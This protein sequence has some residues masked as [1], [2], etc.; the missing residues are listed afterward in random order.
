MFLSQLQ[1]QQSPIKIDGL[2]RKY[3]GGTSVETIAV[4]LQQSTNS[5]DATTK[6]CHAAPQG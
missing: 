6:H 5:H 2:C 1:L 3:L 4:T